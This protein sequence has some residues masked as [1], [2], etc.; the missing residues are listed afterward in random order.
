LI[1]SPYFTVLEAMASQIISSLNFVL[2]NRPTLD[3]RI[4]STMVEA[5]LSYTSKALPVVTGL[6]L[7]GLVDYIKRTSL[8]DR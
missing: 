1:I 4:S 7:E 3:S 6:Q 2:L 5:V 8:D